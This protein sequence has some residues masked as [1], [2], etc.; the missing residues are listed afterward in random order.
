MEFSQLVNSWTLVHFFF[1]FVAGAVF[2]VLRIPA[3]WQWLIVF[4]GI[5]AWELA[6]SGLE[7]YGIIARE[8]AFLDR[9]ISDPMVSFLGAGVGTKWVSQP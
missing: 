3:L 2:Y 4:L 5:V 8:E 6:E 1:W 9:Y 7:S